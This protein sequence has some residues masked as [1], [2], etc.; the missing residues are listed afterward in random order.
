MYKNGIMN[1][2]SDTTF[3]PNATLTRG[4]VVT[5]LYRLE[6]E[7]E[8]TFSGVFTDVAE[9]D[10]YG[11]AVEWAAANGVVNGYGDG[12]F[13][14]NDAVTVEQLAA[15]LYRYAQLKGYDVTAQNDLTAFADAADVSEYAVEAVKWAVASDLIASTNGLLNAK[16][17]AT[18]AQVAFALHHFIVN[19]VK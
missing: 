5:V 17:N 4:M 11:K 9:S 6:N 18:R 8:V 3:A 15:I 13:G 14:P 1:G 10:W 16:T 2:T 7:P 19:V 12:K